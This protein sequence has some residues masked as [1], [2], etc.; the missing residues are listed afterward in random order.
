MPFSSR[1]DGSAGPALARAPRGGS[2]AHAAAQDA[3]DLPEPGDLPRGARWTRESSTVEALRSREAVL[4]G[5]AVE[6]LRETEDFALV[7]TAGA[8]AEGWVQKQSIFTSWRRFLR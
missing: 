2:L 6:L 4:D 3:D 5:A 1:T 7:R 8:G